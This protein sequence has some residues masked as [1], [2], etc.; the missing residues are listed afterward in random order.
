MSG[1]AL[2]FEAVALATDLDDVAVM[3][4]AVEQRGSQRAAAVG[5]DLLDSS[6]QPQISW[7]R[8]HGA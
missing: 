5:M 7:T 4:Q 1:L 6:K 2:V 3:Q 8:A